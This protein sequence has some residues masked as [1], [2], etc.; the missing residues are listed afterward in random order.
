MDV[1]AVS[2]LPDGA[3]T[4]YQPLFAQLWLL[5]ASESAV[6]NHMSK[7]FSDICRS[8]AYCPFMSIFFNYY[9]F[10]NGSFSYLFQCAEYRLYNECGILKV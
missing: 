9:Y 3:V 5:Q 7:Y 2:G 8:V 4:K 6:R 1:K 10:S